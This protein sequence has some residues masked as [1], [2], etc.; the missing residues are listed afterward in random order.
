MHLAPPFSDGNLVGVSVSR[1]TWERLVDYSQTVATW[2]R[3]ISMLSSA[4]PARLWNRHI[5]DSA[6]LWPLRHRDTRLWAD[7][8]TGAGLP[9]VVLAIIAHQLSPDM[10]FHLVESDQRKAA[11]LRFVES[12]QR[13]GLKIHATR[14]EALEPLIAQTVTAR[15]LA[16]LPKLLGLV[17]RHL[18]DGGTALL[19]KGENVAEELA[20]AKKTWCFTIKQHPSKLDSRASILQISGI[21]KSG[22]P[23][24]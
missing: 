5:L 13:L 11:F 2:S 24:A 16:P 20:E 10:R 1:E 23:R 6:Q 4:D 18:A 22:K 17:G 19:P 3:S 8:G 12:R 7:L 14:I 15:A 21:G 9:G